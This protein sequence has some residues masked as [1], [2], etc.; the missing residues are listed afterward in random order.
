MLGFQIENRIVFHSFRFFCPL[1]VLFFF[2]FMRFCIQLCLQSLLLIRHS[3][4]CIFQ[5]PFQ[6]QHG[7]NQT[8]QFQVCHLGQF[9]KLLRQL[10]RTR[11]TNQ[12]HFFLI[13]IDH[14]IIKDVLIHLVSDII[15]ELIWKIQ[16][17]LFLRHQRQLKAPHIRILLPDDKHDVP[18]ADRILLQQILY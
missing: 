3:L 13:R 7:R 6:S 12:I 2:L 10:F 11:R 18:A 17:E 8:D 16:P 9:F 15:M 14:R 5:N 1:C 4:F